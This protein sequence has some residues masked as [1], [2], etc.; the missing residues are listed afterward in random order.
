MK[1]AL[2]NAPPRLQRMMLSLQKYDFELVYLAGKE[3]ILVD[4]LS[5]AHLA[6]TS[7][8]VSEEELV[9]QVHMVYDN[10][11]VTK[12]KMDEIKN[13]TQKDDTLMKISK[14]ITKGWPHNRKQIQFE[15]DE[16]KK[17]WSFRE[18]LSIIDGIIFKGERLIIPRKMRKEVL[19]QLHQAHMGMEKTKWRVRSTVHWPQINQQIEEMIKK[20]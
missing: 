10:A 16:T 13:E 7:E 5:R 18:E 20:M 15:S 14:Y 9:A 3:N 8:E 11:N 19:H 1:K 12:T 4:T 17:Y 2:H 6:D